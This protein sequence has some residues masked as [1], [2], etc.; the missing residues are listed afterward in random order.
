MRLT[1]TVIALLVSYDLGVHPAIAQVESIRVAV[2][3]APVSGAAAAG[4]SVAPAVGSLSSQAR[5]LVLSASLALL[6]PAPLTAPS[7]SLAANA[8]PAI[9]ATSAG[10]SL[11]SAG[12]TASAASAL[13]QQA[14]AQQ[15]VAQTAVAQGRVS[16]A[17][18]LPKAAASSLENIGRIRSAADKAADGIGRAQGTGASEQA[19]RQFAALTGERWAPRTQVADVEVPADPTRVPAV[20]G[21]SGDAIQPGLRSPSVN[22]PAAPK[23]EP[24]APEKPK[25][26]IFQ[27]FNDPVR[28]HA[29]WRYVTGYSFFLFG[30][31]LYVVGLPYLISA[32]TTNSL[33][34]HK[35]PRAGN[36]QALKELIRSNRSLARI[37][38]WSAQAFSYISM[39]LFSRNAEEAGPRKWLVRSMLI[40]AGVLALVPVLFF[41]TGVLSLQ[42][43]VAVLFG[44]IAV[45]SFFQGVSVT[46]EGAATTRLLG[47]KSVT[48]EER[49]KAN[50]ILTVLG[51]VIAIIGPLVAGQIALIKPF[52]G[53]TGVGGAVIYGIYA[54]VIAL[55]GLIYSTIKMF[56]G[57]NGTSEA[58]SGD[59]S[60]APTTLGGTLK[61]LWASIK[62]GTR[63][64]FKDRLMRTMLILSM[65][66]SLFSDPLVFNVL[67]EYIEAL[68]TK[69]PGGLGALLQIPGVGWFLKSL[70]ATPMGNFAL[71]M[72]MASLGSIAATLLMKPL[73]KLFNRMGFK[74]EEA[75]T[76]PFYVIAALEAPLFFLMIHTPVILGAVALYGLQSLAV[77]FIGIA[78]QGLY[79]KRLGEQKD[80]NVNKILAAESL[81]GI[82][83]A[84]LSTFAYGFLLK[85]IAIGTSLAIAAFATLAV[86]LVRLAAP[87]LSFTKAERRGTTTPP[88]SPAGAK[89]VGHDLTGS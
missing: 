24:P 16:T 8:A 33:K 40:R 89:L 67:P 63:I 75:L 77:G 51:A 3:I 73:T 18:T 13:V 84:I 87:F 80:E 68:V 61:H 25:G 7:R 6:P 2:P 26:G 39:P 50:S 29:F 86:S 47:D 9:A 41:A 22:E 83:A 30:Y 58:A 79:Q 15:T 88:T 48:A 55:T 17:A 65:L 81:L 57:K 43:S 20:E 27:V 72:V 54:G 23:A 69:N 60:I 36:E 21:R 85:D 37:A 34:E 42:A 53:K 82:A 49:T 62:D 70:V 10:S 11:A 66:G 12:R 64:V 56:G 14:V 52:F 74:T 31:E 28:N 44:L 76:I 46:T 71:M 59:A 32:M 1:R 19:S 5:S 78:I 4:M 45:Q 35:D 38:H